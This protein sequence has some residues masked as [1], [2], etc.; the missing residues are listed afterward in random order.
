MFLNYR[1]FDIANIFLLLHSEFGRHMSPYIAGV[2]WS[3]VRD[4]R[5]SDVWGVCGLALAR[6]L[7]DIIGGG[8]RYL[9]IKIFK[10]WKIEHRGC[11]LDFERCLRLASQVLLAVPLLLLSLLLLA[12]CCFWRSC[13]CWRPSWCYRTCWSRC[14]YFIW[15][16][17]KLCCTMR[18]LRLSDSGTT[19]ISDCYW[20]FGISISAWWMQETIGN[21]TKASI[22]RTIGIGTSENL[23][24]AQLCIYKD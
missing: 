20:N 21:R 12:F 10:R 5:L 19:A 7:Q 17:Y 16:L 24:D 3:G 15:C 6:R 13:Y 4:F 2:V 11:C 8:W 22:Y 14:S 23:L 18:H 1:W 9:R